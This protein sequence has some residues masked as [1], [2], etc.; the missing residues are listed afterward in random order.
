MKKRLLKDADESNNNLLFSDL[1]NQSSFIGKMF[2]S[3]AK[4][5]LNQILKNENFDD[6]QLLSIYGGSGG[7]HGAEQEISQ[8]CNLFM[9]T[10]AEQRDLRKRSVPGAMLATLFTLYKRNF[11]LCLFTA[12]S[13]EVLAIYCCY[14]VGYLTEFMISPEKTSHY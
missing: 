4:P 14:N 13:A 7:S 8:E 1:Y 6:T 11:L 2:F 3:F 10:Y 5:L 9:H 12:I